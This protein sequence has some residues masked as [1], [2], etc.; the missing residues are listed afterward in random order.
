MV[1]VVGR[2]GSRGACRLQSRED[3]NCSDWQAST[4]QLGAV[5]ELTSAKS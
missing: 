4:L 2:G 3:K 1:A 5:Q